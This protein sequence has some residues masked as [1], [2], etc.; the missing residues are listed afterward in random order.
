MSGLQVVPT[1]NVPQLSPMARP[2][3]KAGSPLSPLQVV[4]ELTGAGKVVS[5]TYYLAGE[6]LQFL[7]SLTDTQKGKLLFSPDPV[8]GA[9]AERMDVIEKLGQR[10]M[11]ALAADLGYSIGDWK[12]TNP[13]SYEAYREF[14]FGM[15]FFW[16]D[17]ARAAV[18][19]EKARELDP[20]FMPVYQWLA[21]IYSNRGLWAKAVQVLDVMEQNRDKLTPEEALFMDRLKALSQGKNEEARRALL[22]MEKIAPHE[23]AYK[24]LAVADGVALNKPRLSLEIFEKAEAP[25]AW[26]KTDHGRNLGTRYFAYVSMAYYL[27]GNHKKDLD[28]VRRARKSF[29]EAAGL[30]FNEARALSALGK[31]EEVKKVVDENLLSSPSTG[32]AAAGRVMLTAARELRLRG[33]REAFK[34]MAGRAVEWCRERPAGKEASENQRHELAQALYMAERWE[35]AGMLIEKLRSE[36]PGDIDYLGYGGALAARRGDKEEALRISEELKKIDRPYTFGAPTYWRARIAALLG[37][38][39]EAV[40]LLRRSLAQGHY[41]LN[42]TGIFIIQEADL[43]PLRDYAPFKELMKPRG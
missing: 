24:F 22:Q 19:L 32:A 40:E 8:K 34:Q 33:H 20:G 26:L 10:V 41:Y 38:K 2:G 4:A 21:R 14:V 18:H 28:V 17:D 23:F 27:L 5:G 6:E 29:P 43:D 7:S 9:L 16:S 1:I 12:A 31:I 37:M 13:P 42:A 35:E 11:G 39:E 3:E 30:L 25:P 15:N 36:R